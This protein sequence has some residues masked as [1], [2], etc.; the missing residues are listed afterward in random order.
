M[1]RFLYFF[2]VLVFVFTSL[3]HAK[4][5]S[6]RL[7]VDV[8]AGKWKS[9]RLRNLPQYSVIKV[10]VKSNYAIILTFV[11]EAQYKKYPKIQRPLFQSTVRDKISFAVKIPAAGH[12]YLVFDN[13]SGVRDVKLDVTIQGASGTDALLMKGN[14]F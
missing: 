7:A 5:Q 9:I 11:D 13:V 8:G 12:Y 10:G 3:V 4:V 2:F 1:K 6:A 14:Y